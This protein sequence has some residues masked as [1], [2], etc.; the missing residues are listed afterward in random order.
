MV[1]KAIKPG[2]DEVERDQPGAGTTRQDG[3][4]SDRLRDLLDL[5]VGTLD[6]PAAD[7]RELARRAAFSRDHLDRLL[8]AATGETPVTLR[9]RLLLE[10]AAWSLRAGEATPTDAAA[11]AGY[12]SLAAFSRAFSRA[13]GVP[14]ASF[15]ASG[16]PVELPAPNGIHF[17][18]PAGFVVPGRRSA[19]SPAGSDLT[20]RL[21]RHH[22]DR[23]R[24]LLTAATVLP[25]DALARPLRPGFVAVWFE[26]EEPSADLMAERLVGTLEVWTAALLGE[27]APEREG[28]DLVARLDRVAPRFA[29]FARRVRDAGGWDDAFVDALCEPPQAFTH[30]G[31]LAHVVTYGAIR[32]EALASVLAE[33]GAAVPDTADPILW[34]ASRR[35]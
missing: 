16:R 28:S 27:P 24:E 31:V 25:A 32:R 12:A 5:V 14:P 19:P 26:G 18:A 13:Y 15:A 30:G 23:V 17:L 2:P 33:L 1:S 34:E 22:L 8:N 11:P 4:V 21:V 20:A 10:R 3:R 35:G 7:G 6:D 9:R 29:A